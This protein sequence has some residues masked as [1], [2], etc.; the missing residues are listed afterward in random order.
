MDENIK[1]KIIPEEW[2][3]NIDEILEQ[4]LFDAN[5]YFATINPEINRLIK[6]QNLKQPVDFLNDLKSRWIWHNHF[7]E[8]L[9]EP[10][11]DNLIKNE[12]YELTE[13]EIDELIEVY[14][15]M[16]LVDQA[17]IIMSGA[18]KSYIQYALDNY[19]DVK[20]DDE[21]FMLTTPPGDNFYAKYFREHLKYILLKKQR[22]HGDVYKLH[23]YLIETYHAGDY[24]IFNSRIKKYEKY[25]D[26]DEKQIKE[27]IESLEQ[28]ES[29]RIKH[30]YFTMEHPNR[31]AISEIV[32][33]DN[34]DEKLFG[35]SLIGISGFILRK[36]ILKYLDD[37]GMLEN[38]GFIYGNSDE[39]IIEALRKMKNLNK[40][41]MEK[42]IHGIK[43]SEPTTCAIASMLMVFKYFNVIRNSSK[44]V[45]KKYYELYKSNYMDGCYFSS[46][47]WLFERNGLSTNLFHSEEKFFKND[48][49]LDDYIFEHSLKEYIYYVEK[50]KYCGSK[51]SNN[52][53][54]NFE[55]LIERLNKGELILLAVMCDSYL[56]TIL[57]SG[58]DDNKIVFFDPLTGKKS[59]IEKE[60]LE[61]IIETPIGKWML[62]VKQNSK[63][64]DKLFEN[65]QSYKDMAT[66]LLK[67]DSRYYQ[68]DVSK[69]PKTKNN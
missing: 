12:Y 4:Q 6:L 2:K 7:Y 63:N 3:S 60:K 26:L 28:N 59:F 5:R 65:L 30:C 24:K 16:S 66:N 51:I 58:Y 29:Y 52:Q 45:E 47:A 68:M 33:Y 14:Q 48:G 69:A 56:H 23:K 64:K 38:D 35:F 31:K 17:T 21:Y 62:S 10:A 55:F 53:L 22:K 37:S 46:L 19:I 25:Y 8:E 34:N 67:Y 9:L 11:L 43:Q 32:S 49:Y 18:I 44:K 50:A 61:E 15:V 57:I 13:N 1:H 27:K 54:I 41:R 39:E 40:N 20:N 42:D 36:K